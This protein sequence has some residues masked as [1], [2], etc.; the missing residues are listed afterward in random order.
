MRPRR[1]MEVVEA[2][3]LRAASTG[4]LTAPIIMLA[5]LRMAA[6]RHT[7]GER[8]PRIFLTTIITLSN[9]SSTITIST[10]TTSTR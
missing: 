9:M 8:A 3:V 6:T 7:R 2:V 5:S 4:M 10:T 1:T